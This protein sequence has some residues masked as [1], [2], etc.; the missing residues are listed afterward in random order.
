MASVVRSKSAASAMAAFSRALRERLGFQLAEASSYA[1]ILERGDDTVPADELRQLRSDE[2]EHV[3]LL[4]AIC[5]SLEIIPIPIEPNAD[6]APAK[7]RVER[8]HA[9]LESELADVYGWEALAVAADAA[10]LRSAAE[11]L[12]VVLSAERQHCERACAWL[13]E[14]LSREAAASERTPPPV[15]S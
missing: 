2:L 7:T 13:S 5:E 6:A 3:A 10:G 11:R 4:V 12:R 1:T 8:L 15:P 9:L 14:E